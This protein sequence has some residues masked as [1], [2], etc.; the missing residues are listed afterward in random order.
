VPP[1]VKESTHPP[2]LKDAS[3]LA[4]R[5]REFPPAQL[6]GLMGVS[7]KLAALVFE[8]FRAWDDK[9]QPEGGKQ[10]IFAYQGD[11]YAGLDAESLL[12]ADV[13]HAQDHVRILSGLYG[14]LRP[15]DLIQPYRLEMGTLLK[16]GRGKD[17]Y[18]F[19]GDRITSELESTLEAHSERVIVNLASNEY[20]KAV[21]FK[22]LGARVVSPAFKDKKDGKFR[23]MQF[24]GK[25]ARGQM[26]RYIIQKRLKKPDSLKK[27]YHVDGYRFNADLS[28]AD[29]WVFTRDAP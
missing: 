2:L 21:D 15:L 10:A 6:G 27:S 20:S 26:A 12:Q 29:D 4:D 13:A 3:Q 5:L 19:W 9:P 16:T 22:K 28:S 25:K 17:L 8:Y 18:A 1:P 11:V 24:F 23:F 7:D 14:V